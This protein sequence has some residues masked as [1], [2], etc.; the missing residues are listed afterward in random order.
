MGKQLGEKIREARN[1]ADLTQEQLARKV[2]G[3]SVTDLKEIERGEKDPTNAQI[4]EIAEAAGVAAAPL[5]R[6]AEDQ[7]RGAGNLKLTEEEARLV[8][9]YRKASTTKKKSAMELLKQG[10]GSDLDG[11]LEGLLGGGNTEEAIGQLL[12]NAM[13]A[14]GK[15]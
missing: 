10:S 5:L 8:R 11:L 6:L 13:K 9:L 2:S 15:K 7:A 14:F 3:L 4:R 12:E 1:Y